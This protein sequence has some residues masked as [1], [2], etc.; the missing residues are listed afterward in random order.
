MKNFNDFMKAIRH[1][2]LAEEARKQIGIKMK[3]D[4]KIKVLIELARKYDYDVGY[5]A[6]IEDRKRADAKAFEEEI[7]TAAKLGIEVQHNVRDYGWPFS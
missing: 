7:Q 4:E 1:G 5:Y 6:L 3:D 2:R